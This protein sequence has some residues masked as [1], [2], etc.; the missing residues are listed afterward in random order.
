MSHGAQ[1]HE[2]FM[3][4]W[5]PKNHPTKSRRPNNQPMKSRMPN[6]WPM[7]SRTRKI[8]L[9]PQYFLEAKVPR[10]IGDLNCCCQISM[11][12]FVQHMPTHV[13]DKWPVV[14]THCLAVL[15][16]RYVVFAGLLNN[17][18]LLH[19]Q[20]VTVRCSKLVYKSMASC[21]QSAQ[22]YQQLMQIQC[23]TVDFSCWFEKP[24]RV[25]QNL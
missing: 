23:S 24:F 1:G 11:W 9:L 2:S 6:N 18:S 16:H 20:L 13:F 8:L 5:R 3:I 14:T 7:K 22:R 17:C 25:V 15:H 21:L 10:D 4:S 19:M 12:L